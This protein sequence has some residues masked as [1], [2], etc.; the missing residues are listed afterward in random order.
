V[1]EATIKSYS[2]KTYFG[3]KKWQRPLK[4][5]FFWN[6]G[7]RV[8]LPLLKNLRKKTDL[9]I[10]KMIKFCEKN[11]DPYYVKPNLTLPERSCHSAW[12]LDIKI[13]KNYFCA[14]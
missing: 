14:S 9:L 5:R 4:F 7:F 12:C 6:T 1:I 10:P 3:L 8:I 11:F 13:F 2:R